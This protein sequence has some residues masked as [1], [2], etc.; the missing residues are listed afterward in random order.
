M[1]DTT[2]FDLDEYGLTADDL[3][4]LAD[5]TRKVAELRTTGLE[6]TT[7][8]NGSPWRLTF[9]YDCTGEFTLLKAVMEDA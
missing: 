8:V 2:L 7:E 9:G 1:P 5:V 4:A 6:L 3:V